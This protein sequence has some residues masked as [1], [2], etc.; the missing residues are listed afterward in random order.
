MNMISISK[1][2][3]AAGRRVWS[4]TGATP[5]RTPAAERIVSSRT[6]AM[7]GRTGATPGRPGATP[8]RTGAT[9]KKNASSGTKSIVENRSDFRKNVSSGTRSIVENRSNSRKNV[10]SIWMGI[11]FTLLSK[12]QFVAMV[13]VSHT[14]PTYG[15][16]LNFAP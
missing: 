11:R 14:T 2:M 13:S 12:D 3:P 5:R 4:R 10:S 15:V 16:C 6:G 7:P 8:G 1:Q 9:P